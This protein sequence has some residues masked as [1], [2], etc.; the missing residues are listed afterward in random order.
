MMAYVGAG[1][2]S[3]RIG[4]R[5]LENL[6]TEV[7]DVDVCVAR[8]VGRKLARVPQLRQRHGVIALPHEQEAERMPRVRVR[9][10]DLDRLAQQLGAALVPASDPFEIR[11]IGQ[12]RDELWV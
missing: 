12:G 11:Q 8:I 10:L 7:D 6:S 3:S 5:Q 9:R 1:E 4:T 2:S